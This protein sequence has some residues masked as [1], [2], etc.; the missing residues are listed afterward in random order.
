M[1]YRNEIDGLRALA[2]L[3]VVLFHFDFLSVS[4]GFFGVDVFFVIS[5]YLISSIL[6]AEIDSTGTLSISQFYLRRTRRILPAL[7]VFLLFS[8]LIFALLIQKAQSPFAHYGDSLITTLFS[9]SNIFFWLN[10]GYFALEAWAEPLLHTWS[11]GVEEQFY[12]IIPLLLYLLAQYQK[13]NKKKLYWPIFLAMALMS[14]AFCRW[15]STVVDRDFI[16]YMLPTRMWE[17]LVGVLVAL[18]LRQHALLESKRLFLCNALSLLGVFLIGYG[19]VFYHETTRIAE[20][21]LFIT[22]ATAL[23]ILFANS[24]TYVG[25]IFST[26]PFRFVGKISYSWY[27]WHWPLVSLSVLL[28]VLLPNI[29][30]VY[31]RLGACAASLILAYFSWKYVETPFRKKRGWRETVKPLAPLFCL[32]IFIGVGNSYE[33][34]GAAPYSFEHTFTRGQSLKEPERTDVG[35]LGRAQGT[36]SFV[37][38]GNSHAESVAPAI[39]ELAKGKTIT[40][41]LIWDGILPFLNMRNTS[42][43]FTS[44]DMRKALS[45]YL[46]SNK[47]NKIL[48]VAR[49]D[50]VWEHGLNDRLLY[51]EQPIDK[52]N[53]DTIFYDEM[54]EF[55]R[56]LSSQCEEVWIMKQV[57]HAKID[58]TVAVRLDENYTEP[59]ERETHND[60]LEKVIKKI[61]SPNIHVLNPREYFVKNNQIS[62]THQDKLLYFDRDHLSIEGAFHIKDLF[63]PFIESVAGQTAVER[64]LKSRETL[65][66][67]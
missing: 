51:K 59:F 67:A 27:L 57:P 54:M 25:K 30:I 50:H 52:D 31:L 12:I 6:F 49:W 40:G 28:S 13:G 17:L 4:G 47:I 38:L 41:V 1:K 20:K 9:V 46:A 11:L 53:I 66:P 37:L 36:P 39:S 44:I 45:S 8:Y 63:K 14:F 29:S 34:F 2:V 23:F 56:L 3:G 48:I 65:P 62:F 22:L 58:P 5:G 7:L 64:P 35:I 33:L 16:F 10:A 15:G 32:L 18:F 42:T 19:F 21:A 43:P 61:D 55:L 60:L 26:P 24:R